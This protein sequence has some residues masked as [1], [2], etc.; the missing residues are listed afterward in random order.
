LTVPA[1][2]EA[3]LDAVLAQSVPASFVET[4]GPVFDM[5]AYRAHLLDLVD[6]CVVQFDGVSPLIAD[7]RV[8]RAFRF[9]AAV[10]LENDGLL[11]IADGAEGG[12]RL[13]GT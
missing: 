3:A 12:L 11:Q 7:R 10:F 4:V 13:M 9:I 5:K 8:D 1:D 6:G 2:I